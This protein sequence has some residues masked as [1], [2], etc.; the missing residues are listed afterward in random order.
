MVS[1]RHVQ[2]ALSRGLE[3]LSQAE[4]GSAL[5]VFFNLQDLS[6]VRPCAVMQLNHLGS[7]AALPVSGQFQTHKNA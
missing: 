3:T 1:M 5:Q 6:Q 7:P 4:V 2:E